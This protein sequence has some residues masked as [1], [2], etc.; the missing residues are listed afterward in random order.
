M[1]R[2][3]GEAGQAAW[4]H[5]LPAATLADLSA[6]DRWNPA[7]GADVLVAECRDQVAG[8]VCVRP[9]AGED[10]TSDVAEIDAFYVH[11]SVWGAGVGLELLAAA[12]SQIAAA[13]F[14]EATLW[15]EQRND[16]AL[17]FYRAGGWRVDGTERR[18][19]YRGTDLLEL[20]HRLTLR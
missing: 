16:R 20:R 18:R 11:P 9:S 3:F 5:I 4:A 19:S 7:V 17:R 12:E 14:K 2:I 6:P 8:F 15:T 1:R 10:A 13:G